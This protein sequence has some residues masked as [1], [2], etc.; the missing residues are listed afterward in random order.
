MSIQ[1]CMSV[2]IVRKFLESN[3]NYLGLAIAVEGAV[4]SIRDDVSRTIELDLSAGIETL[5][6]EPETKWLGTRDKRGN[7]PYWHRLYKGSDGKKAKARRWGDNAYSGIWVCRN[8]SPREPLE[9]EI[10]VAGWPEEGSS[11]TER[12]VQATFDDFTSKNIPDVWSEQSKA[13]NASIA[14]KTTSQ[15]KYVS[16]YLDGDRAFLTDDPR[17]SVARVVDL[18]RRLTMSLD[19]V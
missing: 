15:I 9:L 6:Q 18:V 12:T 3:T 10:G 14:T 13:G 4:E 5:A 8:T 7:V 2:E 17:S 11:N 1:D 19:E 16:R